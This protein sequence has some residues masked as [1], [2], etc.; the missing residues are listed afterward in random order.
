LDVAS[1]LDRY[2][3]DL[4][5]LIQLGGELQNALQYECYPKEFKM[6]LRDMVVSELKR[7]KGVAS[8]NES[9]AV[10]KEKAILEALPSFNAKYQT[11][12]S[13]A[14]AFI[15]QI[16]PDRLDDF[17]RHYE[18]PKGRKTT[19][20]ETYRI[21]DALQG[22][23][24]TRGGGSVVIADKSSAVPHLRQQMAIVA[25]AKKRFESKL[26]EIRQLVQ[27]DLL[28]SELEAASELLKHKFTRAAGAVA[29]V[30]LEKHLSQVCENHAVKI[31]KK[32]PSISDL[33][34]A[35]KS[36]DVIEVPAWRFHQSLADIRN[37]CDHDKKQEPTA[38]QVGDLIAGVAKVS[39][40][41][42]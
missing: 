35:L 40:T 33:N 25:A 1:N 38:D 18:T 36:A 27:A 26:F 30:V 14:K 10:A 2:R 32:N 19:D 31:T 12:Y 20:F 23:R 34:E 16:L 15:R 22:L 7:S 41:L 37:L 17:V 6:Q 39:K 42:Y 28:D 24:V 5:A 9:G 8:E 4:D 29:G 11:W 3:A 21:E 13:E